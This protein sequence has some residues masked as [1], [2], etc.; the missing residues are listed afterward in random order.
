MSNKFPHQEVEQKWYLQWQKNGL[1]QKLQNNPKPV[2][3][4]VFPE[5]KES[6]NLIFSSNKI[7]KEIFTE[8]NEEIK[9]DVSFTESLEL[10]KPTESQI[11]SESLEDIQFPE[12]PEFLETQEVP[13]NPETLQNQRQNTP[14]ITILFYNEWNEVLI[15]SPSKNSPEYGY[16]QLL[17]IPVTNKDQLNLTYI[18]EQI[19][20]LTGL[21]VEPSDLCLINENDPKL[22]SKNN[23]QNNP[24]NVDFVCYSAKIFQQDIL[25]SSTSFSQKYEDFSWFSLS[26]ALKTLAFFDDKNQLQT[27]ACKFK[28]YFKT[29]LDLKTQNKLLHSHFRERVAGFIRVKGTEKFV[30]FTKK[31][32]DFLYAAGGTTDENESVLT[33]Y[34]REVKEEIGI[35][36][37]DSVKLITTCHEILPFKNRNSHSLSHYVYAEILFEDLKNRV[38]SEIDEQKAGHD[39]KIVLVTK[40]EILKNNWDNFNDVLN[41]INLKDHLEEENELYKD[42]EKMVLE[43]NFDNFRLY[44]VKNENIQEN[45]EKSTKFEESEINSLNN[46]QDNPENSLQAN[47]QKNSLESEET[48][49]FDVKFK[50]DFKQPIPIYQKDAVI[51]PII[52]GVGEDEVVSTDQTDSNESNPDNQSEHEAKNEGGDENESE[53]E[54]SEKND[55]KNN[56]PKDSI[57]DVMRPHFEVDETIPDFN[58]SELGTT[59][60]NIHNKNNFEGQ[61]QNIQNEN[62]ENI[63]EDPE[64][65]TNQE[66]LEQD[67][68]RSQK[69]NELKNLN[70]ISQEDWLIQNQTIEWYDNCLEQYVISAPLK[71][72]NDEFKQ[73]IDR[74]LSNIPSESAILEIGSGFGRDADYIESLDYYVRR[75]DASLSMVQLQQETGKDAELFNPLTQEIDG[76]F[77]AIF[78]NGVFPHFTDSQAFLALQKLKPNLKP[79]G[80]MCASFKIGEGAEIADGRLRFYWQKADLLDLFGQAGYKIVWFGHI[81]NAATDEDQWYTVIAKNENFK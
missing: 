58:L 52:S 73:W 7:K 75:T 33:A 20:E 72:N 31:D 37:L 54:D 76:M 16:N 70:L 13:E 51:L 10:Q 2:G 21:L 42:S 80:I 45:N 74:I 65:N 79:N 24:K 68:I 6:L 71:R 34:K 4:W 69:I 60:D 8:E 1:L 18:S 57:W 41:L 35:Q 64:Q 15:F 14:D 38:L 44:E 25:L 43:Y 39:G 81:N 48:E 46:P 28:A 3:S 66:N 67:I 29:E 59:N 53:I 62:V 55:A 32:D 50:I 26:D 22:D 49:E 40:E 5:T 56:L 30:M 27:W 78:A 77:D 11:F 9:Q 61:N 23:L 17:H 36:N 63:K 19:L 47:S 12:I